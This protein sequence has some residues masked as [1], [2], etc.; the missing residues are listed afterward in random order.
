[1]S[2]KARA[3][4]K[5]SQ[6]WS[7]TVRAALSFLFGVVI[8]VPCYITGTVPELTSLSCALM[9]KVGSVYFV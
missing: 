6:S 3:K 9:E 4:L 7:L 2:S 5:H 1:M 8:S